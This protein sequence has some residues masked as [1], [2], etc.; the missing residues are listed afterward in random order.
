MDTLEARSL[1]HDQVTCYRA[2]SF[3]EL[4]RLLDTPDTFEV[5]APSGTIYQFEVQA[6]WDDRTKEHLR[7]LIAIDDGGW[8]ALAPMTDDF[9]IDNNGSFVGE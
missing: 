1:L 2:R 5:T 7:V 8:R 3:G 9:I 4:L 6:I